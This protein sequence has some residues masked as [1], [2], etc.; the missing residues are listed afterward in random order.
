MANSDNV[1]RGGLTPKHV[2]V[3]EMLKIV[4]FQSRSVEKITPL[5]KGAFER[6][7]PNPSGEFILCEISLNKGGS[8]TGPDNRGVEIMI[9]TDGEAEIKDLGNGEVQPLLKGRSVIV[10]AGVT[11]YRIE[12]NAIIYK[13]SVP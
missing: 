3:A 12:G 9:C 10:P 4:S 6:T 11:G 2:D 8:V 5:G 7:Y 13:A 1:L